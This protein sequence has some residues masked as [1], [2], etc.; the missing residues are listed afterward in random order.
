MAS[1]GVIVFVIIVML[2]WNELMPAIFHL[3]VITFWQAL[4]LLV[5]SKIFFSSLRGPRPYWRNKARQKWM[6]MTPE[7][8]DRFREEWG[9]RCGGPGAGRAPWSEGRQRSGGEER[10]AAAQPDENQ[11]SP[12]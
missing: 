12:L 7:E 10:P 6:D 4:G 2:L 1:A 11:R 3:P 9:R 5:L 8:R